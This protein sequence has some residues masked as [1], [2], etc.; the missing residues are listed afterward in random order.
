MTIIKKSHLG[1]LSTVIFFLGLGFLL[2][3]FY[4]G[5]LFGDSVSSSQ[6]RLQGDYQ[7]INPL[8]ECDFY[9]GFKL[10]PLNQLKAK[11]ENYITSK[12]ADNSISDIGVYI[13]DLNNGP[14]IGINED[15]KF[16]PASLY[17][18]PIM[19]SYLKFAET[20]S[21]LLSEQVEYDGRFDQKNNIT[22]NDLKI[23]AGQSYTVDE[24]IRYMIVNSDNLAASLLVDY[25][26]DRIAREKQVMVWS[27]LGIISP[28]DID[29]QNILSVKTFSTLFRVLYNASYLDNEMSEYALSLLA[30]T[31]YDQGLA[32]ALPEGIVLA[33]KFGYHINNE[34]P[35]SAQFHDCG[36]VYTDKDYLICVMTKGSSS[37]AIL[38]AVIQ[39]ISEI[40][41]NEIT[42]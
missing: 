17:K 9:D 40:S 8:L 31:N 14:W 37:R 5:Y 7:L 2:G 11:L 25:M 12:L 32:A 38:E 42:K 26:H 3:Y 39:D 34:S 36:I 6:L 41:Y 33:N 28:A 23:Q 15:L 19:I 10:K 20:E 22:N 24:L 29:Q 35:S 1:L 30:S 21:G 16:D 13:R 18:V 27:E 4:N